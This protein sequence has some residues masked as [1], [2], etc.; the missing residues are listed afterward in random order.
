[1]SVV[2]LASGRN[3]AARL[4]G[5][6]REIAA[7]G[8]ILALATVLRFVN[9]PLR[10]GWDSDQGT[11]MLALRH[12]LQT[13]TLPTFGPVSS[14]G[15]FHHGALSRDIELPAAWLG[16]GD[17]I[18]VVGEVALLSL[19]VVIAAWWIARSISGQAAGLAAALIA[20]V[21]ASQ[22]GYA[23]FIWNPTPVEPGAAV[24]YLGAWAAVSRRS[25]RWWVV[26]AAGAA[27]AAQSHVAAAVIVVPLAG[28]FALDLY[29]GPAGS[30]RSVLTWGAAGVALFVA[31]Y[32]PQIAFELGHDFADERGMLAYFTSSSTATAFDPLARLA[33]AIIRILAW[34][35]TRWPLIELRP[36]FPAALVAAAGLI[37]GLGWRMRATLSPR[38]Q[39]RT[40]TG[41]DYTTAHELEADLAEA[42]IDVPADAAVRGLAGAIPGAMRLPD[43]LLGTWL[44]GLGLASLVLMLGLGLHSVSEVQDLPTEQYHIVADPLVFVAAGIVLGALWRSVGAVRVRIVRRAT[45]LAILAAL[46]AWNAAHVPP[47]DSR[48]GGWPAAQAA[49]TRVEQAARGSTVA[50]VPLFAAKGA[51]AYLYPLERDGVTLVSPDGAST[52][53]LLCDTYWL[54]GCG[55]TAEQEWLA[56]NAAASGLV[57]VDRFAAAPDRLLSVYRRT[58]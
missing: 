39:L 11:E 48:D 46:I 19:L 41:S 45:V 49:A 57:L 31:T 18:W 8:G 15:N 32:L 17:P 6:G 44:V 27:L 9:L 58:R 21:S 28:A 23:T 24:A 5:R 37:G 25:A 55:G 36:A 4:G 7:L 56:Q 33:F 50:V 34:P 1:M 52:V 47:L 29:R 20:A 30:R 22:I 43:E 42:T 35:L 51:D 38:G 10:G 54:T 26:A 40:A 53:V 3:L 2:E 13:G 14:L 12:A 16:N